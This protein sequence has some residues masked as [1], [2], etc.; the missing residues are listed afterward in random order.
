MGAA[1]GSACEGDVVEAEQGHCWRG[2]DVWEE[3]DDAELK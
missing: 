3:R 2:E 1:C